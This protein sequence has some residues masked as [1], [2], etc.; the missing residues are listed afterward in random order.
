ML[1]DTNLS[2]DIY[3]TQQNY[4]CDDLNSN[5]PSDPSDQEYDD[6]NFDETFR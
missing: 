6:E 4:Q 3:L 1:S 2:N 5:T